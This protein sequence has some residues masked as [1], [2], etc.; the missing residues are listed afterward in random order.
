MSP[1]SS[2]S[3]LAAALRPIADRRLRQRHTARLDACLDASGQ[4][5]PCVIAEVSAGGAQ[6]LVELPAFVTRARLEIEAYGAFDC[7][8]AWRT[9]TRVGIEF[10]HDPD[11]V[12]ERLASLLRRA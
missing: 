11:E 3:P 2:P 5:V 4:L 9:D 6:L 7:R 10:L 8:I 1:A 12:T